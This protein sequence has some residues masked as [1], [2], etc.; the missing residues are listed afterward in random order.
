MKKD[1]L[2]ALLKEHTPLLIKLG[3]VLVFFG[4]LFA[5]FIAPVMGEIDRFERQVQVA[6]VAVMQ[7]EVFLPVYAKLKTQGAEKVQARYPLPQL[8]PVGRLQIFDV[9]GAI[10]RQAAETGLEVLQVSL[11][12]AGAKAAQ[13]MLQGVF[14][15]ELGSFRNFFVGLNGLAFVQEIEK[16]EMRAVKGGMEY[17]LQFWVALKQE[18][19]A[20]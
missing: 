16:V 18:E 2:R 1:A 9:P 13:V 8:E 4:G 11:N 15:G 3:G 6:S 10:E 19:A 20:K 7:Q 17:F 5:A 12:P 14:T